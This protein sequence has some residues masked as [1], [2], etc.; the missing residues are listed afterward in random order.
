MAKKQAKKSAKSNP[1]SSAY[2]RN[3]ATMKKNASAEAAA[4]AEEKKEDVTIFTEDNLELNRLSFRERTK[5]KHARFRQNM[6]G[7][8]RKEK[9]SYFLYYYKWKIIFGIIFLILAI[10]IPV[11]I[12]KS[13]RPVAISYAVIN[14][15][16]PENINDAAFDDYMNYY[17]YTKKQQIISSSYSYLNLETYEKDYASN[18][19][20]ANFTSFPML[21]YNG[22][23]DIIITDKTGLEY[24][25]AQSLI[26]PLDSALFPDVYT[27]VAAEHADSIISAKSTTGEVHEYGIDISDTDLARNM[28][29][30]YNDIYVGFIGYNDRNFKN[31]RLFL[32]YVFQLNLE[33]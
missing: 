14:S 30:D 10:T 15:H 6:E 1:G 11:S 29:L 3:L 19:D 4:E 17:G 28:N 31:A 21:C 33:M 27:A 13:S 23:F 22:Y 8:S 26:Q 25:A 16:A 32:N 5:I 7:M 20:S 9:I 12:Y 18:P 24:C 2:N